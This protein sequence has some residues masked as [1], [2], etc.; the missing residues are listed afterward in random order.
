MSIESGSD[1]WC[2]FVSWCLFE[3]KNS[4]S[5]PRAERVAYG[6]QGM[7]HLFSVC[8]FQFSV[9]EQIWQ[10]RGPRRWRD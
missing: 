1:A 3:K 7:Q 9:A 5:M 8:S 6:Q 10:M 2:F 4:G